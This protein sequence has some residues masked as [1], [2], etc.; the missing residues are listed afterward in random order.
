MTRRR[1]ILLAIFGVALLAAAVFRDRIT[2]AANM[3]RARVGKRT[4]S[5]RLTEF[6]GQARE[7]LAPH[8]RKAGAPF[9]PQEITL[10][11]YKGEKLLE[12][13]AGN[14]T[15]LTFIRTYPILAASGGLGPKLR[16]GDKQVPEGF[17]RIESLN[18][19]STYHV[20]LRLNYPNEFDRAQAAKEGRTELGGDIMIHGKAAS[21]GCIAIGDVAAEEI[22][23]LAA[24]VGIKNVRVICSPLDFRKRKQVQGAA[25]PPWVSELYQQIAKALPAP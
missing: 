7:R 13:Y 16:E 17:Y 9:P 2:M 3:V 11:A 15:N 6:G 22:F 4:V 25:Q 12:L 20:S 1:T 5:D 8:F 10:I 18:P 24:D 14:G 23:T 21:I 19:N